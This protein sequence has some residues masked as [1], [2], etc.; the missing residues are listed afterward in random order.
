MKT[1]LFELLLH[2]LRSVLLSHFYTT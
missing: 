2:A 1:V